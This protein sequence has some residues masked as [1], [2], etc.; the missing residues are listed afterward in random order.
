MNADDQLAFRAKNALDQLLRYGGAPY[1]SA[2]V[3]VMDKLTDIND[4][5]CNGRDPELIRRE[6]AEAKVLLDKIV[7]ADG[8]R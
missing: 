1:S 3:D 2:I 4:D 7:A 5:L 8:S 6:I